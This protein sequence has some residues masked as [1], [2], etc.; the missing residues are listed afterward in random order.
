MREKASLLLAVSHAAAQ[1]QQES[2][3]QRDA[4][5]ERE[6]R[7]QEQS[8]KAQSEQ[9]EKGKEEAEAKELKAKSFKEELEAWR[10]VR[11]KKARRNYFSRAEVDEEVLR[12]V[13]QVDCEFGLGKRRM[14]DGTEE[15]HE[16]WRERMLVLRERI[17]RLWNDNEERIRG[18]LPRYVEGSVVRD[19]IEPPK[20]VGERRQKISGLG[21]CFQCHAQGMACS[22][23]VITGRGSGKAL[24][25]QGCERCERKGYRC[26]V[27][28]EMESDGEEGKQGEKSYEWD[29]VDE[30]SDDMEPVA[31]TLEMWKRRRRG[32][33]LEV[34]GSS[35]Q[36]VEAGGFALPG[37]E[38]PQ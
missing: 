9:K 6:N 29:W 14:E 18:A 32:D 28:Y 10:C 17:Y 2:N 21:A 7:R 12:M 15:P 19:A 22:R 8:L 27:E 26:I 34:I 13:E 37:R 33:K 3:R 23:G 20:F 5:Q 11:D 25:R 38:K 31:E 16:E 36:W 1:R 30:A 24:K 4:Q 35:M